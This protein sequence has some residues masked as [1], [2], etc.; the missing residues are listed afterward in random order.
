[1]SQVGFGAATTAQVA[2]AT[3]STSLF[4]AA[5]DVH[6]RNIYNGSTAPCYVTF[7][8]V[9]STTAYTFQIAANTNQPFAV[10]TYTGPV[11]GYWAA[12]NGTAYTTQW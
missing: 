8:T 11:Y 12:A 10:P 9:S 5:T 3:V 2:A 7:G 6:G 4:S 1:M